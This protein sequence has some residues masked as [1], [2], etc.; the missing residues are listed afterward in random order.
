TY[1]KGDFLPISPKPYR[2]RI[3][4]LPSNESYLLVAVRRDHR[5][6]ALRELVVQLTLA[7][8]GMLVFSALVGDRLARASLRPVEQYR[9]KA[10]AIAGGAGDLLLDVPAGRDDEVTRLGHT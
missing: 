9:R 8:L 3:S 5:D 4:R 6:E 10:A 1:N 2:V 7:G